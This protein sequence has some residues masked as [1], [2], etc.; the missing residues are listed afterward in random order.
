M[1]RK[2]LVLLMLGLFTY[3]CGAAAKQ[4]EFWQHDSVYKNNEH[5]YFSWW[6]FKKPTAQTGQMSQQQ[7]WWGIP[8]E[9]P[10]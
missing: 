9:A 2:W 6:D 1:V 7:K 3:G 10:F 4:S 5:M 8:I